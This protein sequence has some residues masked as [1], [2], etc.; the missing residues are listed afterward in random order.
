MFIICLQ[1][2]IALK[3]E[4]YFPNLIFERHELDFGCILND[5]EN[6]QYITM[7]NNSPL[8]V[9]YNWSFLKRPPVQ[10]VN[11]SQHDEGVDMQ[12]EC[13]ET[14]SLDEQTDDEVEHSTSRY[15]QIVPV[16]LKILDSTEQES[17]TPQSA[18]STVKDSVQGLLQ[19]IKVNNLSHSPKTSESSK[20]IGSTGDVGLQP[21]KLLADPFTPIR[22]EQVSC[23]IVYACMNH[24][25]TL[26]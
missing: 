19:Q 12:S 25:M 3:S 8:E 21:W 11:P 23:Y 17:S 15:N 7:T 5:T 9:V 18:Q 26:H 24:N 2:Q 16:S 6:V 22:I 10:R 14:D 13:D 20:G 1:D 4:V